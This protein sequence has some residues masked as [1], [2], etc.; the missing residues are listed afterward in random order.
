VSGARIR[1]KHRALVGTEFQR[2][3]EQLFQPTPLLGHSGTT[4]SRAFGIPRLD[5]QPGP[6]CHVAAND[7][8]ARRLRRLTWL[9]MAT[10]RPSCFLSEMKRFEDLKGRER[11]QG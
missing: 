3:V 8:P 2:L 1:Q 11:Y 10:T 5:A 7:R 6:R 4:L 9:T